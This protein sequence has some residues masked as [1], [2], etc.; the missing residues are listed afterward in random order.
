MK[1]QKVSNVNASL[2]FVQADGIKLVNIGNIFFANRQ[3][4]EK[5]LQTAISD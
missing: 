5:M 4:V 1:I 3:Q 2:Q